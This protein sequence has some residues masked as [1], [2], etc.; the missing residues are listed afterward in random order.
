MPFY[1][2]SYQGAIGPTTLPFA[3]IRSVLRRATLRP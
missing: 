3:G 2:A 1:S